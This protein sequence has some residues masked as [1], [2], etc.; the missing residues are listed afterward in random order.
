[1][2]G[3]SALL[4][5]AGRHT[6]STECFAYL[7]VSGG[8]ALGFEAGTV[9]NGSLVPWGEISAL[10]SAVEG[11]F[12]QGARRIVMIVPPEVREVAEHWILLEREGALPPFRGIPRGSGEERLYSAM[13]NLLRSLKKLDWWKIESGGE[14][15]PTYVGLRSLCGKITT[16][17]VAVEDCNKARAVGTLSDR[18]PE[19]QEQRAPGGTPGSAPQFS[20]RDLRSPEP[21]GA[22]TGG[23]PRSSPGEEVGL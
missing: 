21:A 1:M 11:A 19:L 4:Y 20:R 17:E 23:A 9:P 3:R 13:L 7:I 15:D 18:A 16:L 10:H 22:E 14:L 5:L 6:V 8:E 2:K 12:S